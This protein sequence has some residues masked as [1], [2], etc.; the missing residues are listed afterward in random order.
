[1]LA[2]E[3]LNKKVLSLRKCASGGEGLRKR[4]KHL[5]L[6]ELPSFTTF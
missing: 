3:R 5:R 6:L 2:L 1:M 4:R